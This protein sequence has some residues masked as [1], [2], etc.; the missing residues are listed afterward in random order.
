M[1]RTVAAASFSAAAPLP[2]AME[3]I[4]RFSSLLAKYQD[5]PHLARRF[6]R[7]GFRAKPVTETG[8]LP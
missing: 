6:A 7:A 2:K 3:H 8:F 5:T 4:T 1:A